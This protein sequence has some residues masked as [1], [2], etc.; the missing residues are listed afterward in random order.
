[1]IRH[2]PENRA[3]WKTL[4]GMYRWLYGQALEERLAEMR[5]DVAAWYWIGGALELPGPRP[6][7]RQR[8]LTAGPHT[9]VWPL[10]E[11]EETN[12]PSDGADRS[13][14]ARAR[15]IGSPLSGRPEVVQR[16]HHP[17]RPADRH[18]RGADHG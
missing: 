15:P 6:A 8:D 16:D 4:A 18:Q 3:E 7:R 11:I 14:T 9:P 12:T 17:D 13:R 5:P 2:D 1:M 10:E